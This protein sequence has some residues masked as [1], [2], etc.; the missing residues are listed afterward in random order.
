MHPSLTSALYGR[1]WSMYDKYEGL[2]AKSSKV[3]ERDHTAAPGKKSL[4]P[5]NRMPVGTQAGVDAAENRQ[6]C[7][8]LILTLTGHNVYNSHLIPYVTKALIT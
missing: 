6:I 1:H 3:L 4:L 8:L 7:F 2:E 5:L